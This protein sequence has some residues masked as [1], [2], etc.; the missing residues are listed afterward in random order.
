MNIEI[1]DN[2]IPAQLKGSEAASKMVKMIS[3]P[4]GKTSSTRI[5]YVSIINGVMAT[6]IGSSIHEK[7]MLDLPYTITAVLIALILAKGLSSLSEA[8][9]YKKSDKEERTSDG[10]EGV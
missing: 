8:I 3:D 4:S 5:T 1:P 6:W 2:L 10:N 9:L 7:T